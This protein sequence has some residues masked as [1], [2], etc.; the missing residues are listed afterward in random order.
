VAGGYTP[1]NADAA[2]VRLTQGYQRLLAERDSAVG[3][4][5]SKRGRDRRRTASVKVL[6]DGNEVHA[7]VAGPVE[8]SDTAN[9]ANQAWA[10][11]DK[12]GE[13]ATLVE[14]TANL[15]SQCR[16]YVGAQVP[17]GEKLIDTPIEQLPEVTDELAQAVNDQ[18]ARFSD[19]AG[20]QSGVVRAVSENWSVVAACKLVGYVVGPDGQPVEPP[21]PGEMPEG[22]T[23]VWRAVAPTS[24]SLVSKD[25]G[26][27]DLQVTR[28]SKITLIRPVVFDLRW[29]HPRYPDESRGWVMSALDIVRDLRTFTM[30]QRSAARS[31]IPA[32]LL[33]VPL[34][35]NPKKPAPLGV[36]E[37]PED[38]TTDPQELADDFAADVEALIGEFMLEVINDVDAGTGAVPGVLAV[39]QD[40]VEKFRTLKFA[41]EVDR[42]LGELV[43]Q[44]RQR[45]SEAADCPPETLRGFGSTNRWNG[46]QIA[47]D[48][49]RRYF[50]PKAKAMADAFTAGPFRTVMEAAGLSE[51]M[52]RLNLRILVD[53][54]DAVA[55]PDYSKIGLGL[56][57]RAVVGPKGLRALLRIPESFAPDDDELEA[58]KEWKQL[59]KPQAQDNA[60]RGDQ[61]PPSSSEPVD[62]SKGAVVHGHLRDVP[63]ALAASTTPL[64]DRLHAI[65]L[66]ARS[67]LEEACE[68][69]LDRAMDRAAAKLRSWARRAK[70]DDLD[71]APTETAAFLT[72][73]G[74][75]RR[76]RLAGEF[77]GGPEDMWS[78]ALSTLV[79]RYRTIASEAFAQAIA[80]AEVELPQVEIDAAIARGE[81]VLVAGMMELAEQQLF[82]ESPVSEGEATSLRV[83]AP[84]MRRVL[85]V[86][87]GALGVGPGLTPDIEAALGIAFGPLM[88]RE[89]KVERLE[90][91][92]GTA[93]RAKHFQPHLDL[94][95]KQFES[96]A[97]PD[98][99]GSVFT[100]TGPFWFPGDHLGCQCSWKPI[101]DPTED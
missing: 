82:D 8:I 39:P 72:W 6:S 53:P 19:E 1:P 10:A 50:K 60:G 61:G 7:N 68:A 14:G 25:K 76:L 100:T 55:P 24:L 79:A 58:M 94:S 51:V 35:A 52:R 23:E 5:I 92:Y 42:G 87:G 38:A 31:G 2:I 17:V 15:L 81:A 63:R 21:P 80:A 22:F 69:A 85:A 67:R 97:D 62:E 43:N 78:A 101:L 18:W 86:A 88:Q 93:H 32:D 70:V 64:G 11:F 66:T 49:Y 9:E 26:T 96:Q 77:G 13:V 33:I 30:A 59:A 57:D 36:D 91:V 83:P 3:I 29:S 34:E 28:G 75:D 45:L 4:G 90:W 89:V 65:D 73:L 95:G 37:A 99:A 41:R 27:W 74:V 47:D 16:F 48:E 46:S 12:V 20:S 54:S 40:F 98:L 44:S 71:S 84:L 56:L